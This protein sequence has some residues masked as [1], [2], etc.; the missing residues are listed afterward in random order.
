[1]SDA[2]DELVLPDGARWSRQLGEL[3]LRDDEDDG[4]FVY[5]R[6]FPIGVTTRIREVVDGKLLDYDE[7]FL[8]GCTT[9]LRQVIA[10]RMRGVPA[11]LKLLLGHDESFDREVGYCTKL[12]EQDDGVYGSFKLHESRDIVK[13]RSMLREAYTGLSVE[14]SDHVPPRIVGRLVE[15]R[16]V[17]LHHVAATPTPA[18]ADAAILAMREGAPLVGSTPLLDEA[19]AMLAELSKAPST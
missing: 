12:D 19:R 10:T 11:Y 1:M 14:F 2:P 15:R 7:R 18:Y 3:E 4:R 9:R 16:Q 8:S 13:V 17:D 5:G 6:L